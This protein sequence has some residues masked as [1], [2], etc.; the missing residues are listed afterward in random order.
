MRA[1]G[2]ALLWIAKVLAVG[3]GGAAVCLMILPWLWWALVWFFKFFDN[4]FAFVHTLTTG[5]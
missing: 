5:G 4:Y 3:F 2:D 1:L